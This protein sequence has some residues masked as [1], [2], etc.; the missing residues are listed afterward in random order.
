MHKTLK[1][2]TK[3]SFLQRWLVT[4]LGVLA[5]ARLVD[6]IHASGWLALLVA[7]FLLGLLNAFFRPVLMFLALP[8]LIVTL[9]LFT[10]VINAVLLMFVSSVVSGFQVADFF[11]A[12]EGSILIS[13]VSILGN[14]MLGGGKQIAGGEKPAPRPPRN[15]PPDAGSGPVIDV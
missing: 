4:T 8:L 13:V 9:G 5:A 10:L 3:A 14:M 11:T 12:I 7:S 1:P 2:E 15:E 6:G